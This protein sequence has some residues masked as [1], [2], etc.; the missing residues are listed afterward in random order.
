M[1]EPTNGKNQLFNFLVVIWLFVKWIHVNGRILDLNAADYGDYK[2]FA[3]NS[4]GKDQQT[5]T[6]YGKSFPVFIGS[7]S[8]CFITSNCACQMYSISQN[9][10]AT[11][12]RL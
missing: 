2:C 1:T 8:V 5:M 12:G 3:S 11:K 9:N 4:L 6:L 10:W 7:I